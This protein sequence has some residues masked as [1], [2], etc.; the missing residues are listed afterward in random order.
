MNLRTVGWLVGIVVLLLTGTLSIS[1]VLAVVWGEPWLPF[2]NAVG[3]GLAVG[4]PLWLQG[5]H[6]DHFLDHRGAALAVTLAWVSSCILGSVPFYAE[7]GLLDKD[8]ED[9]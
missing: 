3:L 8:D 1:L 6:S 5:R 2:A 7:P 4:G 9:P